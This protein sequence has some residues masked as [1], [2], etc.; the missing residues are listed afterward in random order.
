MVYQIAG[1]TVINDSR[2]LTNIVGLSTVGGQ[3]IIGSGNIVV[4]DTTLLG[5]I[6]T[7]SGSSASLGSLTLTNY[8]FLVLHFRN[9]SGSSATGVLGIGPSLVQIQNVADSLSNIAFVYF[10]QMIIQLGT[11]AW[12]AGIGRGTAGTAVVATPWVGQTAITTS[13]TSIFA[14]ISSGNFDAGSIAV[15]GVKMNLQNS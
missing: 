1:T 7:T 8:D 9:V 11:G 14:F 4:D 3:S 12:F 2:Q 6:T 10:G 13:T 5:S 15:Y